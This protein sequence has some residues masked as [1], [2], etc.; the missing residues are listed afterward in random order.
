MGID[1][2][3]RSETSQL[4]QTLDRAV[5]WL[6]EH[7]D[8]EGW[9][10]GE[11]ETNVTM[12]AEHVLLF[13]FLNLSLEPIKDGAIRHILKQQRNDGSWAL[14]FGGPADLSTTIEAYVALKVLGV[15]PDFDAMQQ[16]RK[17]IYQ[18]GGVAKARVFTKI[19]LALF[20]Q[21]PWS[22]IPSMPPELIYLPPWIPFNLY[23]FA[24]WARGTIAPLLIVISRR[25]VRALGCTLAELTVPGTEGL[26]T[27]VPGSGLFWWLDM[28]LKWYDALPW[29]PGRSH[30]RRRVVEW[31]VQRQEADGSWGG[32]QP[33]WVYSLIALSLEGMST[34]HPL[35]RKGIK[36]LE[37]FALDDEGGW[38]FQACMSP[39]WDTAWTLL[40]LRTA[41]IERNHS[42]IQR[43]VHWLLREQ[44]STGGDW[45]VRSG[46]VPCGGWA[47]EFENDIYPDIDDTAVVVLALLETGT[48]TAIPA[49][50]DRAVQWLLVMRSSNG[51]WGAFDK[52]NTREIVYRLPFADFGALLDPPSEDVT[53]HVL[54]MLAHVDAPDKERIIQTALKYLRQTQRPEGCWFEGKEE[55]RISVFYPEIT[56]G[57]EKRGS[58]EQSV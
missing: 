50:V 11:L 2:L 45:Q 40:A 53:A 48:E 24:C 8:E 39:I 19:W 7:Q 32:I 56:R 58:R 25:P 9:W 21:Y 51:A 1:E 44:I 46:P 28:L 57:Y 15:D 55:E 36:G 6:L 18:Q 27:R 52:D 41:G 34:D 37:G 22:G 26:L 49:A 30:A 38:R 17:V 29:Q 47:F 20:G 16:A 35:M 14:Y 23:D 5:Q 10:C 33:P 4:R 54:E 31:I 3:N 43:A 42:G 12:T 13:R